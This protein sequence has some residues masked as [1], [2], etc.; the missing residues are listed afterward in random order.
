MSLVDKTGN[1][2]D[3]TGNAVDS[4]SKTELKLILRIKHLSIYSDSAKCDESDSI[5]CC[6]LFAVTMDRW[7]FYRGGEP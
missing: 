5:R 1:L 2:V 4:I 7:N 3:K 6:I